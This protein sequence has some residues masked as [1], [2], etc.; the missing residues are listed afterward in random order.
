[1]PMDPDTN[2]AGTEGRLTR[3]SLDLDAILASRW[4]DPALFS[5][6]EYEQAVAFGCGSFGGTMRRPG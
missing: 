2:T 6:Q 5:L 3:S 1:M 4:V